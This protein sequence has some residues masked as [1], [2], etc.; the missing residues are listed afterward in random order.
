MGG[1]IMENSF[2]DSFIGQLCAEFQQNNHV[3]RSV[4]EKYDIKRGL[5]NSDGTGVNVGVTKVGSVQGYYIEDG[6]RLP[7]DGRLYYRG[8]DIYELI[9]G[10]VNDKRYGYEEAAY[11]LL[12]GKLPT[13]SQLKEFKELVSEYRTLP[14]RFTEDMI[15]SA[16]SKNIMNKLSRSVLAM[17]SYDDDPENRNLEFEFHRAIK[18]LARMPVVMAH[19]YAAKKHYFDNDSLYLHRPQPELSIAEN[20]LYAVRNDKQFTQDEAHLLDICMVLHAEHGG[21]NNSA[22]TC[23]VLSSADTD[24]YSAI[25]AAVGSLKGNRH[26]GANISVSNMV[27]V[28]KENITDYNDDEALSDIL[29]KLLRKELGTSGLIYGIGHA[30]YTKSDPRAVLLKQLSRSLAE[31]KGMMD[32]YALYTGIERLAPEI[33]KQELHLDRAPCANVDLYSGLV[34]KMLGIPEDL[35]TP[36]FAVSRM[37]GWCAHRIEEAYSPNSKIIRPAY[38]AMVKNVEYKPLSER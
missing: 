1:S 29:R 17:Y 36:I 4:Y 3:D 14:D 25:A 28:I 13:M 35:Y 9:E 18:L 19:A 8:I 15:L 10:F 2:S 23:R 33:I 5:R 30:I 32:E 31:K 22:F 27:S 11:L 38:K 37:A 16:P 7:M 12:F 26:G 24:I 34:Y 6:E 21:G 20:I